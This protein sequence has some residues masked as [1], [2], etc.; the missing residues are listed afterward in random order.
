M[1]QCCRD[2]DVLGCCQ[3]NVKFLKGDFIG[4]W[5]VSVVGQTVFQFSS[6]PSIR[7]IYFIVVNKK[8]HENPWG[9][10]C[11]VTMVQWRERAIALLARSQQLNY[12]S[13]FLSITP[14]HTAFCLFK[15]E[16]ICNSPFGCQIFIL[17]PRTDN[18]FL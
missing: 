10:K 16:C 18:F 17:H 12:R 9:C 2:S 3:R 14:F 13:S 15:L 4:L 11:P 6:V 7:F 5:L 8:L 1:A